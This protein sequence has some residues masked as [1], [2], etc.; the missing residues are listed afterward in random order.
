MSAYAITRQLGL[1][2][3]KVS[4]VLARAGI[5]ISTKQKRRADPLVGHREEIIARY[6]A[7]DGVYVLGKAFSCQDSTIL[8]SLR[9]WGVSV[10]SVR[11]NAYEVDETFFDVIDSE[12]KAYTLGFWYADGCNE[13]TVPLV[14]ISLIDEEILRR[15]ADAL[16]W[17]GPVEIKLPKKPTHSTQ[18]Q[19]RIG[20]RRLSDA[21]ARLGCV[22]RKT[23]LLCFPTDQQV[24][25]AMHRHLIRGWH[26]GDGTL[27]R[28]PTGHWHARIVGTEA[29][30]RGLSACVLRH[31][32]FAGSVCSVHRGPDHTTWGFTVAARDDLAV[33]LRWLYAD[34]TIFL[35]RKH[36]RA[37]EFLSSLPGN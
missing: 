1:G 3:N 8:R 26:D 17:R 13:Q 22:Q 33:Y 5:D 34:A 19:I 2:N 7:G 16:G 20:S 32:G 18:Y 37:V 36:A 29:A 15:I 25:P 10:R 35:A 9:R 24:P 30:C 31:L 14:S 28:K 12:V 21:L 4:R 6:L 27:T 23:Y 11:D